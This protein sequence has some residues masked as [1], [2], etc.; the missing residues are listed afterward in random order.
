MG[1][2][3]NI[4]DKEIED[5]TIEAIFWWNRT[6]FFY[7]RHFANLSKM[8][9]NKPLLNYFSRKV[10]EAF[11]KDYS[12]RRNISKGTSGVDQLIEELYKNGFISEV[13]RGNKNIV[14]E[15]SRKVKKSKSRNTTNKETRSLL[16]KIAF[17][18]N[19]NKYSLYDKL[20]RESIYKFIKP[21]VKEITHKKLEKYSFFMEE[22]VKMKSKLKESN[23]FKK[24]YKTLNKVKDSEAELFFSENNDAF[25]FRIIDKLLWLHAQKVKSINVAEQKQYFELLKLK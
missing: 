11:S 14:D 5:A 10:F 23:K 4:T 22:V 16:S 13:E 15:V 19:P 1:S 18:I 8:K 7:H 17:L 2:E 21:V 25:E 3:Y 20:A 6:E 24:S 9:E 12:V